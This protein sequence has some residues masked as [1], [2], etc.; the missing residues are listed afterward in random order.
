M[1]DQGLGVVFTEHT[2]RRKLSGIFQVYYVCFFLY[3]HRMEITLAL[4]CVVNVSSRSNYK[5]RLNFRARVSLTR[6]KH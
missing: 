1:L 4:V 5:Q 6:L 3:F 2:E